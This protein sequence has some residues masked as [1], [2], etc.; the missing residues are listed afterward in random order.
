MSSSVAAASN[1]TFSAQQENIA[2]TGGS[3]E[4]CR[5][6]E[7]EL[8]TLSFLE[9]EV[10]ILDQEHPCAQEHC[11]PAKQPRVCKSKQTI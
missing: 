2:N 9:D 5:N 7:M 6:E 3:L 8:K 11:N 4:K 10:G 1:T